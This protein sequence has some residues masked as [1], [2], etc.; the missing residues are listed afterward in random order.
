MSMPAIFRYTCISY[1][2]VLRGSTKLTPHVDISLLCETEAILGYIGQRDSTK[3]T[4]HSRYVGVLI[5]L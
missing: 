3:P 2:R 4:P 5:R 1:K